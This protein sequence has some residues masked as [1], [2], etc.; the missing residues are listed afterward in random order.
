MEGFEEEI[1]LC[2]TCVLKGSNLFDVVYTSSP[3]CCGYNGLALQEL[4][5]FF[6]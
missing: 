4:D 1:L 2:G 5:F 6:G 3:W